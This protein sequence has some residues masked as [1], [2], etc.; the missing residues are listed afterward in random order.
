MAVKQIKRKKSPSLGMGSHIPAWKQRKLLEEAQHLSNFPEM[1][2][3]LRDTYAWQKA[4]LGALNEKHAKVALK[5]AN[6]SGK[7]SMV[8]ASAVIWH[9]LRWPGSLVVCT[10]GVYRQVADALWPHLRKMINGLGGEENGFSI[11]DG[12]IRYVYPRLVDGQQ[13][14]SRC[15]GFSASNPEKAEGWHVQGPSNDLMYIVDE[16]KAVPDGIF[17]SMERCQPTRTLLMSSPGGS[18]GYFYDVFRRNDGK[19]KT[20]TV[21][22]FDCPHIRKEWIDDQFARWGEGHP[23]VRSMIYAEFMEDDGSLTAV[24]TADW[25][26]LVSGPPKEDTDGHRLTAGCDF[27]AGGDESVMV[28]RQG[29]TVKGLIRWRDKDTM[30]SV[31]RFISEFRKWK[32]KAE[33]IYADVGGMGV[34]M[35]DALRAEG[36]DVRRVNFGERAIRDDQ[37]VNKAAEMWIEFGRMVEEGRVNLGPVGTDEVL[38]QQFVSRKVR[39]NGKGKLTLEGKDELRARGVNSPDRADAVVLAFCGAGGKRMDDYMKALGEDGRSLLERM[40]DEMGAIE[41]DGKGS[42]LAGCEVGG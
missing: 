17:Q 39:T 28:V 23:L 4:V 18:S 15:I 7:T 3:G 36:W 40:E 21:T 2:L 35:C 20:F 31:G 11:K 19:W 6:G 22:A 9:M 10:A 42:A 29:N 8:A 33:D 34:V 41:G 37:F 32:L 13:L 5:A 12:E 24:R 16:A 14:I 30:A 1:M 26:K 38:L 27:S 25:Q